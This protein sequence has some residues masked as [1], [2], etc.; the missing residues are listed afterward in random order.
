[1]LTLL[2]AWMAMTSSVVR[3]EAQA[4]TSSPDSGLR[5]EWTAAP[6]PGKWQPVCGY[7]YNDTPV[8]PREVRLLVE[9]RDSSG[10]VVD[11]R[12]AHVLGYIAPWGRTYFCSAV[13]A[14]ASRYSV[15]VLGAQWTVDG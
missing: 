7:L 5:I 13:A 1:V 6:L 12:V 11:S 4:R 10:Q 3:V 14:G 8:V 9:A 2:V 15:T